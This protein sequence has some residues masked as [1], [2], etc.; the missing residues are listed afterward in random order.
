VPNAPAAFMAE[1]RRRLDDDS[2]RGLC[3]GLD[4]G[5]GD[6]IPDLH[7]DVQMLLDEGDEYAP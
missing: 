7:S 6:E 2:L 3:V 1:L 4:D 5:S